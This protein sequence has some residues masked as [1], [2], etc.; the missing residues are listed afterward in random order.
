VKR[1][2]F[3]AMLIVLVAASAAR[4]DYAFQFVQFAD[5]GTEL[6]HGRWPC[7]DAEMQAGGCTQGIM[8]VIDDQPRPVELRFRDDGGIL[9]ITMAAGGQQLAAE[10]AQPLYFRHDRV[11]ATIEAWET[12]RHVEPDGLKLD[13]LVVHGPVRRLVAFNLI[14]TRL[15][16]Q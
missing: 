6:E 7:R 10:S 15:L 4:A 11:I 16:W 5:D 14:V 1:L 2:V 9:R 8:L 12:D 3:L 13:D